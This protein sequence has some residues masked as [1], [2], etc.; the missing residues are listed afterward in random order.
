MANKT[1]DQF[2]PGTPTGS[3]LILHG[4]PSDGTLESATID[5][6]FAQS[7]AKVVPLS[8]LVNANNSGSNPEDMAVITIPANTLQNN[9]DFMLWQCRFQNLTASG[10]KTFTVRIAGIN[11]GSIS[12]T[13]TGMYRVSATIMRLSA[14]LCMAEMI[15]IRDNGFVGSG[16][17]ASSAFDFTSNQDISLR[18]T[19]GAANDVLMWW[20]GLTI[21]K[22]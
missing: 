3:R 2:T 7:P 5:D 18:I 8:T 11:F 22:P 21:N 9:G 4:A 16:T 10:T 6:L 14:S 20:A 12:T 13:A 19:A 17:S 1:Y 15:A